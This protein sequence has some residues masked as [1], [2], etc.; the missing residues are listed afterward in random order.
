MNLQGVG[1]WSLN[2]FLFGFLGA[3]GVV[4]FRLIFHTGIC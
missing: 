2:G 3:G 4:V 1:M